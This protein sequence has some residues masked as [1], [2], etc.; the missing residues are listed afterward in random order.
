MVSKIIELFSNFLKNGSGWRLKRVV[1]LIITKS[2]QNPNR[3]SFHITLP[4]KIKDRKALINMENKDNEC[5]KWAVTRA[6]N[7]VS[8]NPQRITKELKKQ[9][10]DLNCDG[11]EFPTP[12]TA[13][14]FK[15]FEKKNNVS[16]NVFGHEKDEIFPLYVSESRHE[17]VVR[18]FFQKEGETERGYNTHYCVVKSMSR[19]TS[20]Q[21]RNHHARVW[22]CDF[23]LNSFSK[24]DVLNKHKL[25]CSQHDCVHT[26]F[27]EPGKNTLRFKN[28]ERGV[29]CPIKIYADFESILEPMYDTKG[30][31][32]LY[33]RHVPSAF[34]FY[35]AS[36]IPGFEMAPVTYVKKGDEDVAKIFC[37]KLEETTCKIYNR[38]KD[39]VPMIF[40]KAAKKLY[41]SQTVCYACGEPFSNLKGLKKVRDHCHYTGKFRGALHSKCNLRLRKGNTIPVFFHNLEGYDSHLFVKRLAD[42]DGDVNCIPHNE[43]KYI[44]FTKSVWVDAVETK[45]ANESNIYTRLQFVDTMHFMASSLEKLVGNLDRSMFKH[46]SKYFSTD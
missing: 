9:A 43:E 39:D 14:Q 5:F 8:K 13:K 1:K 30:N 3:G 46:T 17:R 25:S 38:F 28:Y 20:S 32:K 41:D 7:F 42:T 10:N 16:I 45:S 33:Q 19:L 23:C 44:T 2:R 34:C 18:L 21:G 27:P 29:E 35:V 4:K 40:D 6:L 37:E 24:E 31:T 11:I 15:I 22:V 12:C 26:I 36:R